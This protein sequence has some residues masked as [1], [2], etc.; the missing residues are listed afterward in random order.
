[1]DEQ[2]AAL[3]VRLRNAAK[4]VQTPPF[5]EA[6]IRAAIHSEPRTRRATGWR[7]VFTTAAALVLCAIS[8]LEYEH[9]ALRFNRVSQDAYIASISA[10]VPRILRVGLGDHVHCAVYRKYP[11]HPENVQ[12]MLVDL[13]PQFAPLLPTVRNRVP[14]NLP[15]VMAHRCTYGHRQFVHFT[16]RDSDRLLSLVISKKQDGESL[17]G[18]ELG[19]ALTESGIPIYRSEAQRFQIAA[20]N[21]GEYFAYVISDLSTAQNSQIA[22]A[23]SPDVRSFLNLRS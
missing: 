3:T 9:G 5:M 11:E 22:A 14:E 4:S 19:Q 15:L 13:G 10:Y 2:E 1:M 12:Q 8:A 17:S 21:A 23:L 6:R 20:F 16:F 18:S 7:V